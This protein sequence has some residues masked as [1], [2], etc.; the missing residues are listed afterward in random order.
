MRNDWTTKWFISSFLRK[1]RRYWD[2]TRTV[3]FLV[4]FRLAKNCVFIHTIRQAVLSALN[5][6]WIVTRNTKQETLE[7]NVLSEFINHQTK[8]IKCI[9]KTVDSHDYSCVQLLTR[10]ITS[11]SK[12]AVFWVVSICSSVDVHRRF[13]SACCLHHQGEKSLFW[14]RRQ[15]PPVKHRSASAMLHGETTRKTALFSISFRMYSNKA[16]V[17]RNPYLA[18]GLVTI[19]NE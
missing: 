4:S 2:R 9:N 12:T 8:P 17:F 7:I 18:V 15:Q 3:L 13:R 1:W 14:W 11:Y 16:A 6:L 10:E 19:A 5:I